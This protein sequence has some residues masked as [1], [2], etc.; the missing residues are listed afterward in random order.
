ML[1]LKKKTT[2]KQYRKPE[3]SVIT[4]KYAEEAEQNT[5]DNNWL[6]IIF[7]EE[8]VRYIN[9]QIRKLI[10]IMG[11]SVEFEE[12]SLQ[13]ERP[14]NAIN[15]SDDSDDDSDQ[16]GLFDL[17]KR[18]VVRPSTTS[19]KKKIGTSKRS[20]YIYIYIIFVLWI[21]WE[22]LFVSLW[23]LYMF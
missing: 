6:S 8:F 3:K 23:N 22:K 9:T 12:C 2:I 7:I 5:E 1:S 20:W 11:K 13:M 4:Q 15:L 17:P 21:S 14:L 16:R 18:K 10:K 19:F